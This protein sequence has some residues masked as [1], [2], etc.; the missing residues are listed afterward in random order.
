MSPFFSQWMWTKRHAAP[1]VVGSHPVVMMSHPKNEEDTEKK[2][3][4]REAEPTTYIIA[5]GCIPIS[6]FFI[7]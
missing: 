5:T 2:T 4:S 3:K 1:V 6:V 7:I